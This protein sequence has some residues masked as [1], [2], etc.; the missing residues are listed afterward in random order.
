[1][2]YRAK[3]NSGFT[4]IELLVV[5][6]IIAILAA[7]LFPVFAKARAKAQQTTCLSNVKQLT[8]AFKMYTTDNDGYF[9]SCA[10]QAKANQICYDQPGAP[11]PYVP[12]T[13]PLRAYTKN[14]QIFACPS[15]PRRYPDF[16]CSPFNDGVGYYANAVLVHH[17]SSDPGVPWYE[18]LPWPG[19]QEDAI[20]NPSEIYVLWDDPQW[21]DVDAQAVPF[22]HSGAASYDMWWA[23][24][25]P[26]GWGEFL[27]WP[28]MG[29]GNGGFVDGHAEYFKSNN[30]S[31]PPE[32]ID[33]SCLGLDSAT[34]LPLF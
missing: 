31:I 22:F 2:M 34:W 6:A 21:N 19:A 11:A 28:H 26:R 3:H 23:H 13:W 17:C 33:V 18:K 10:C 4:L 29:G 30:A 9:P 14:F 1:M 7:I 24:R 25:T 15:K 16:D 8:L 12:W 20:P 32:Q 5:I 27:G